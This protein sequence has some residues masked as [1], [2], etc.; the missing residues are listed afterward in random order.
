MKKLTK[1]IV[2]GIM[3]ALL[4]TGVFA[5][6]NPCLNAIRN[7]VKGAEDVKVVQT[8]GF[9]TMDGNYNTG[10]VYIL[11]DSF[12]NDIRVAEDYTLFTS[13]FNGGT[14]IFLDED[15]DGG[16]DRL[17]T[18]DGKP[19]KSEM[20]LSKLEILSSSASDFDVKIGLNK[21][22]KNVKGENFHNTRKVYELNEGYSVNFKTNSK[23]DMTKS[24]IDLAQECYDG[25]L[26]EY[27]STAN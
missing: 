22:E 4:P 14:Q 12:G 6:G 26:G 9:N 7:Y 23:V 16:L 15:S 5:D 24:Q 10:D 27:C 2:T 1:K 3:L 20:G 13:N 8:S 19:S 18:F 21:I 11:A 17:I 25:F